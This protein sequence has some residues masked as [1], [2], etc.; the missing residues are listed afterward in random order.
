MSV[1]DVIF[2]PFEVMI[3][4]LDIPF[5]PLPSKG[6]ISVLWHFISMFRGVL[7]ALALSSMAFEA[8]NLA[9]IWG[10]SV[11]V[12]G[13]TAQGAAAFLNNEMPLLISWDC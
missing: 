1:S 8:I 4:P 9:I 5:R 11:I 10:L 6:P 2:R 3:R 12:D 13:V 7:L